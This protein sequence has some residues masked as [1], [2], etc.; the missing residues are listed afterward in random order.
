MYKK[1]YL[2]AALVMS[3]LIAPVGAFA[4]QDKTG[5]VAKP[6]YNQNGE[7][8]GSTRSGVT[9]TTIDWQLPDNYHILD[10]Q[11]SDVTGD[12]IHDRVYLIGH[13]PSDTS[14]Y[15]DSIKLIIEN[16]ANQIRTEMVLE[17]MGGYEASLFLGDFTGDHIADALVTAASGGSG[18]WYDNKVVT[19]VN[20]ASII[21]SQKDN[22]KISV[23][24]QFTNGYKVELYNEAAASPAVTMDVSERKADYIRL[25]LYDKS[26]TLKKQTKVMFTPFG[27][28]EPVDINNDGIYELKGLQRISGAYNADG[29][30]TVETV[31]AYTGGNWQPRSVNLHINLHLAKIGSE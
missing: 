22:S 20:E 13:Q 3:L 18:G 23:S 30:A 25:G 31:L 14:N 27:Q 21:F 29:L 17:E 15:T 10:M 2:S 8:V 9:V 19:F 5:Y 11:K 6:V 26:G 24:G 28:L 1:H 7:L 4:D 16:G 12:G